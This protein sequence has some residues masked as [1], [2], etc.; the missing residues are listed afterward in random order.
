MQCL[1]RK[2]LLPVLPP[3][4]EHRDSR[5]KAEEV[6]RLRE[7]VPDVG[8]PEPSDSASAGSSVRALKFL[9]CATCSQEDDSS[10]GERLESEAP[11]CPS[12]ILGCDGDNES[13][14]SSVT[15]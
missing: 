11:T 13:V 9:Q 7:E 5:V 2:P 4:D 12:I 8:S 10:E 1:A 3:V 15:T 14:G 6:E